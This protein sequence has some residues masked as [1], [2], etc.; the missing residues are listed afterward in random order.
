MT[1][2]TAPWNATRRAAAG[3]DDGTDGVDMLL[4]LYRTLFLYRIIQ[5]KDQRVNEHV[6]G[7]RDRDFHLDLQ[8]EG[9]E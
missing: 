4:F 3:G 8:Q 2:Q 1:P 9:R 5:Y 6:T 7:Y